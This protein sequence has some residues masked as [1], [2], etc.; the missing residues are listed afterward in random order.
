M[1]PEA[2]DWWQRAVRSLRTAKKI[3]DEDPDKAAS[4][5]YYAAF[6]AVS[7]LFSFEGQFF[8][9]HA[10]VK[11]AVHQRLVNS[12]RWPTDLGAAYTSLIDSRIVGDYGGAQH[13]SPDDALRA[14]EHAGAILR[15]VQREIPERLPP[16]E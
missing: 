8:R 6:Y 3:L 5:A 15:A 7:A 13:V 14:I 1:S 11:A 4:T 16:I 2:A 9:K 12:G 10:A